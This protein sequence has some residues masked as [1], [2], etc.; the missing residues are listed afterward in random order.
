MLNGTIDV[1]SE[2]GV[3]TQVI[4]TL[5]LSR[6]LGADTPVSTPPSA[7]TDQSQDDS[8]AQIVAEY[9][10]TTVAL[11]GFTATLKQTARVVTRYIEDWYGLK[12][13]SGLPGLGH[14]HAD[15]VV[16][17]E[18]ALAVYLERRVV[19]IPA[20]VLCSTGT[21]HLN[22]A[23]RFSPPRVVEYVSKPFGPYKL[24][25]G[26]RAC[27]DKNSAFMRGP[28]PGS[29]F[30]FN[31]EESA[32]SDADTRVPDFNH[33]SLKTGDANAPIEVKTNGM[34][35]AVATE[36]AQMALNSNLSSL[37]TSGDVTVT[38]RQD[39]PF[40][41]QDD[42]E[43]AKGAEKAAQ[44]V[45]PD[46][47]Q[48]ARRAT[49]PLAKSLP[50]V[51][52]VGTS[53]AEV[54]MMAGYQQPGD[55]GSAKNELSD[56]KGSR[57]ASLTTSNIALHNGDTIP[58]SNASPE[59]RAREKRAPRLLLVDD[60]K[61]NLRL[62][63]T[64]MRKRKYDFVDS[65]ENGQLAVEAAISQDE[66]YDIIF[67]DISMPIMNG[68]EA[69]R[70]IRKIEEEARK[71]H[72]ESASPPAMI[73]A[74]TGLASAR[75]QTEAFTSGVDLFMTKPVSFK[76]VGRLLDNWELHGGLRRAEEKSVNGE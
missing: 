73:I 17:D 60:N 37:P 49:A 61:I 26:I 65:A 64:F 46:R 34:V 21:T 7:L 75:D 39:F 51:P 22:L 33:L 32:E 18:T 10:T 63:E 44:E 66:G 11:Y 47:P 2:V 76:E 70:A 12:T 45:G 69:T 27:L 1:Q 55:I 30:G 19:D 5:P 42:V 15:L 56:S 35:T 53:Q 38:D 41:S 24:V 62:L 28:Q 29:S 9:A 8:I 58:A 20:V 40:P 3:G 13:I 16:L 6:V 52:N 50:P 71:R 48:W 31:R 25:R 43:E 54:A 36:N 57:I 59:K 23:S 14:E 74:L 67:M 68:F 72:G 4:V